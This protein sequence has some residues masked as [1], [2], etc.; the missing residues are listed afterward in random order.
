MKSIIGCQ[1]DFTIK[2]KYQKDFKVLCGIPSIVLVNED[3]DWLKNMSISLRDWFNCNC[4]I[5]YMYPG[6]CFYGPPPT[7]TSEEEN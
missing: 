3:M 7:P 4:E 5:Y 2:T 6:E 1:A